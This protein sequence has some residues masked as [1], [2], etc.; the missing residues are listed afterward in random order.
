[1]STFT[2]GL[3]VIAY[4]LSLA[5]L[6]FLGYKK[7]TSTSDYL[8]GGRQMNPIV[9]ALSYGATFISASAIV[10][11]GGVAAAFGMGIQWLCY[12]NMFVGV[13]IAF[14]FFGLRTRRMGAKL[15]VS[16][17]PQ[18]L[19]RHYRSRNIQVFIAVVIFLGMPLYAAV[20]M[21]GGA[22]FIEQ[23]FQVD[24]NISLLIFTLVIAAYV[25]AGGMK[26]VMYT[27]AL[28]AI[29]MFCCMLFLLF[30]LYNVLEMNFTEANRALKDIAPLVPEHYK[31][32]GHQGWTTMP[33]AGSPQ[34]YSLVTSLIL[35]VGIGCL[36]QPQLI[37]RFMT[38]ESSKQLN[39]GIF[40][41]C[42]FLIVTV[43]VIYH[44]GALS[45][46]FFLKTEGAI[47]T[48]VVKDIDKI[49]PYFI[50]K[51]MPDWFT[52]L[53][54]LCIL[55]ASM[56]TLSAQ[57]HTMGASAGSD[58]YGTYRPRSK[59]KLTNVIRLGVLISI[60]ISYIVCYMLPNDII[61]RG[62]AIFMGI[63]AAAFLPAYFCALYWKRATKQGVMA[64]L[65]TGSIASI[66]A[67]IFLH[68]KE[69]A[70][71][72]ICKALFGRDVLIATYPFPVIDPILFA[73]PL[74]ILVIVSV[75]LVTA[76]R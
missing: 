50:D 58:I 54:M 45:N 33:I 35:G 24:F 70:A 23:I 38:V 59:R 63:C 57:F 4:L 67:L 6:G 71:L 17:F 73:L 43:G 15:N 74:S 13:I 19:G 64:S 69:S 8:V 30:S 22:V 39:R 34:W 12:L 66:F 40:I 61:A 72:G 62:T 68:E 53:F 52:A 41:G 48:E 60:L 1:M 5:Y 46:L 32:L 25:I 28:Q 21:K 55:S 65:W 27:D 37:V 9:M 29:I 31:A 11:F 76:K 14:L 47:A 42:L 51:A 26:G 75:S 18:L 44:A 3:I 20:V 7:T 49:I 10:G 36:A 2:L 56:S 16:T